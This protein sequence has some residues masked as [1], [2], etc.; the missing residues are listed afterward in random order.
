MRYSGFP[1]GRKLRVATTHLVPHWRYDYK[2]SDIT[3]RLRYDLSWVDVREVMAVSGLL[4][5]GPSGGRPFWGSG[6]LGVGPSRCRAFS[7]SGLLTFSGRS[8]STAGPGW[9]PGHHGSWPGSAP[10][11]S[12]AAPGSAAR[13]AGQPPRLAPSRPA[14]WL[15][16][17]VRGLP[18]WSPGGRRAA[19][20]PGSGN[21]APWALFF[22]GSVSPAVRWR[23]AGTGTMDHRAAWVSVPN[24]PECAACREPA[25]VSA[26]SMP[27]QGTRCRPGSGPGARCRPGSGPGRAAARICLQFRGSG[28]P[29]LQTNRLS[30]PPGQAFRAA[31]RKTAE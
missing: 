12:R 16:I 4:G 26:R 22:R 13:G 14:P 17:S 30:W 27:G 3:C 31:R 20:Y 8:C 29:E 23:F 1:I 10:A 19:R 24:Q 11:L 2:E 21:D 28:P 15:T 25:P 6:L 18:G 9:S 7:G 5:V